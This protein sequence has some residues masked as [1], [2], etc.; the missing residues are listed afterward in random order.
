[1]TYTFAM[2]EAFE[3]LLSAS[4]AASLL[5]I[6]PN[7]LLLWARGGRVPS[8]RLGRRVKFRASSLNEWLSGTKLVVP[9]ALPSP[10]SEAA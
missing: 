3:S 5:G 6:H 9:F 7:T 2:P 1:M 4:E 8:L 10:E